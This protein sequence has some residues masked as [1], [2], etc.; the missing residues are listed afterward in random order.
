MKKSFKMMLTIVAFA[1]GI[2]LFGA[3]AGYALAATV[4][5]TDGPSCRIRKDASTSSEPVSSVDKG[6]VLEVVGEKTA[7][8]G[9]TWYEVKVEGNT[10][11]SGDVSSKL[12]IISTV[13]FLI[14]LSI[15]SEIFANLASV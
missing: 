11:G 2:T 13:F 5:V 7:S 3:E 6:K 10:T 8:D 1:V 12:G 15:S 4:T 9:Y 14:S